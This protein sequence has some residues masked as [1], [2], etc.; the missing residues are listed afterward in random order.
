MDINKRIYWIHYNTVYIYIRDL[1]YYEKKY[2]CYK[3]LN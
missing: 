1:K 2:L 3:N